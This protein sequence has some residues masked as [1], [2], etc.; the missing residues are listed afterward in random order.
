MFNKLKCLLVAAAIS[1]S[2]ITPVFAAEAT[3]TS[4]KQVNV[5][6]LTVNEK[7]DIGNSQTLLDKEKLDK[8]E[9]KTGSISLTLTDGKPGTSKAGISFSCVKV[10]DVIDG[11]YVLLE[12]YKLE[13]LDLNDLE[14]AE[15]LEIAASN[16]AK[17]VDE[18]NLS[19]KTDEN[20]KLVFD[21]LDI[22]VYLLEAVNTETYDIIMPTLISIPTWDE[23]KEVM[24]YNLDVAPKHT[25][26]PDVVEPQ[27]GSPQ[28]NAYSPICLYL[29]GAATLIFVCAIG[30]YIFKRKG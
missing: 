8:L 1:C 16:I 25:P 19:A 28:T 2:F 4:D 18:E 26:H 3:T 10:A 29:G 5:D 20:G 6:N 13:G 17:F 21:N 9:E 22:G 11:K 14:N 30:N 24:A 7:G 23:T 27:K 15:E 12:P